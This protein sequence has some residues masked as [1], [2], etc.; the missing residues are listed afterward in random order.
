MSHGCVYLRWKRIV[1]LIILVGAL[2]LSASK[3]EAYRVVGI[4]PSVDVA[5]EFA[6]RDTLAEIQRRLSNLGYYRGPIDGNYSEA[7]RHAIDRYRR[8]N[9]ILDKETI[10]PSVLIHMKA[11]GEAIQVQRSLKAARARQIEAARTRLLGHGAARDLISASP[12]QETADP[13]HDSSICLAAPTFGCL[14]DEAMESI[15]GV[16]QDRYRNWALQDLIGV[17]AAAGMIDS[18]KQAIRRLT[19]ARLVI[20]SLREGVASMSASRRWRDAEATISL[21]PVGSDKVRALLSLARHRIAGG[22]RSEARITV[23]RAV[24]ALSVVEVKTLRVRLSADAAVLLDEA[25][26][27]RDARELLES[28]EATF[29]DDLNFEV[30]SIVAG[31]YAAIG[32]IEKAGDLLKRVP[33]EHEARSGRMGMVSAMATRNDVEGVLE[34]AARIVSARYRTVA[35]CDAAR[36]FEKTGKNGIAVRLLDDAEAKFD[37][38]TGEFARDYARICLSEVREMVGDRERAL[39]LLDTVKAHD[40][41]ARA[42]WRMWSHSRT[43]ERDVESFQKR[44]LEATRSADTF[45]RVTIWSEAAVASMEHGDEALSELF[46][47]NAVNLVSGMHTRWW[48]ARALSRLARTVLTINSVKASP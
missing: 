23:D 37:Q 2:C 43:K 10:W 18:M 9:G 22:D 26:N 32:E 14:I 27:P 11:L 16:S 15:R 30:I 3:S 7:T 34:W 4:E 33:I 47:Q 13:T 24:E 12:T 1:A 41:R 40:L 17:L 45:K 25:S 5:S 28:L 38:I 21:M 39:E 29:D 44:A 36:L 35:L 8:R 46:L 6:W 48:R 20:V 19:D 42:L 31:G